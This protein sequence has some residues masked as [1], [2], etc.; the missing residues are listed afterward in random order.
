MR[1]LT[2]FRTGRSLSN[3]ESPFDDFF[4]DFEKSLTNF[5]PSG[6]D[7]NPSLDIEESEGAYL[8]TV[9]LPGIKKDDLQI[10]MTGRTLSISGER[11]KEDKGQGRYYERSYGRFVRSLTLPEDVKADDIEAHYEDG[12]LKLVIAKAEG[13][14]TKAI[15]VQSGKPQ[16]GLLEKFF[17]KKDEKTV[18]QEKEG[19]KH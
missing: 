17:T 18:S 16:G 6:M 7:F 15:K 19:S 5:M 9:D 4:N 2:P 10:N 11:K 8:V 13:E 1:S 3:W 14:R 12:V